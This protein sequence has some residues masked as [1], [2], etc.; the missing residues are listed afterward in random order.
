MARAQTG[1]QHLLKQVSRSFYLTLR[2]LPR[3]VRG[4]ISLAYLL[5]RASD[6]VADT[7]LVQIPRKHQALLQLRE[8]I[9]DTCEGKRSAFP[10][11]GDLAEAQDTTAGQGNP[12]ER[13]LLERFGAL[14]NALGALAP[15]D[16]LKIGK[17]LDTILHGQESDLLRFGKQDRLSALGS[18]AELDLYTYEVAGCVGEFWTAMCRDHL[19][20]AAPLDDAR[21]RVDGVRFGKGLQLVNILRD[22]PKDLRRGR[23]YIP[24]DQ[25]ANHGLIPKDLLDPGVMDRF[26]P[27]YQFYLRQA[28]DHLSAGWEYTIALPFRFVRVRLACAW[29]LLIAISTL[30]ELRFAN[31]LDESRRIKVSRFE[32]RRLMFRSTFLYL[33]P[34]AWNRLFDSTR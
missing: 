2:V 3:S 12:A 34:S 23:C 14:L 33:R 11:F 15:E 27:L 29:P 5:A 26:Q 7:P 28:E 1:M 25:L 20:P 31:V 21:L 30:R 32:M 24:Q 6:T 16:R 13:A 4:P 8:S 17:L 10:D 18:N 19:F 22:L 9:L